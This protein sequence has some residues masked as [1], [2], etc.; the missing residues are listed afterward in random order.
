MDLLNDKVA[1]VTGAASGIG[2]ECAKA[3]ARNGAAVV[4]ADLA[5]DG[6]ESV[7]GEIAAAGG[8]SLAIA[9]DIG[10]PAQLEAMVEQAVSHFGRLD[11]L[12]NN[13]AATN[14]ASTRDPNVIDMDLEAWEQTM[15]VNLTGTMLATKF[16]L[17]HLLATE[18]ASIINTSSGVGLAGDIGHTAYAVS[19]AGIIALTQYTA[20]QYGK[21]GVRCNAVAPG[22]VITPASTDNYAG[23]LGELML[24]HHLTP[25]LGIPGDIAAMVVFLSSPHASFIT[26]QVISVDGGLGT[27]QPY[28]ADVAQLMGNGRTGPGHC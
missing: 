28:L 17:P 21:L 10:D 3:L 6:A 19:K 13:A 1:I 12:H 23:P 25:R 15:R 22:L 18:D 2:R 11:I 7:A 8:Q 20:A 9:V 16:A 4:V 14:L 5:M 24:R 26:G 27:H